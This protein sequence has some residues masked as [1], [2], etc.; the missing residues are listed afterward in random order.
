MNKIEKN[1]K[2]ILFIP[3]TFI[4]RMNNAVDLLEHCTEPFSTFRQSELYVTSFSEDDRRDIE[5][6]IDSNKKQLVLSE[7]DSQLEIIE[8]LEFNQDQIRRISAGGF[9]EIF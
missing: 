4:L 9:S 7:L 8:N 6:N 3:E 5:A 2:R 1:T